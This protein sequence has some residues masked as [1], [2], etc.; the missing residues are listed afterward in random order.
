MTQLIPYLLIAALSPAAHDA[1]VK[2]LFNIRTSL[3]LL[4]FDDETI[5]SIRS[6]ILRC[7]IHPAFLRVSEGRKFLSFLFSIHEGIIKN[8]IS[9]LKVSSL[10][11][12]CHPFVIFFEVIVTC[13]LCYFS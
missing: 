11:H 13:L 1:D 9:V 7:F 3:L 4:D 10:L 2:R 12:F 5:E 8:I 6:L